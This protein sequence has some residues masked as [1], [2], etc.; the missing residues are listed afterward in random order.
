MG[1]EKRER[2][3]AN[4]Q[5]KQIEEARVQRRRGVTR[6]AVIGGALVAAM[7]V[8]VILLAV[9]LGGDDDDG[10]TIVSTPTATVTDGALSG[11]SEP[12]TGTAPAVGVDATA[13][14]SGTTLAE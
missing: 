13:A 8:V 11:D 3:K 2:Q 10:P 14:E 6:K 9:F 5:Q 1:T 7:F 12:G 4:R